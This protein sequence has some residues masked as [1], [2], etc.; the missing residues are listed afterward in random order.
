MNNVTYD[1]KIF[2]STSNTDNGEI[3]S[4]TTF[5]YREVDNV[6]WATY[7]GG[8]IKFGTLTGIKHPDG[9]LD[10]TY[11]HVNTD[12]EI[13]TGRCHSTPTILPDGRIRLHEAWQWTT[14]H[15]TAGESVIEE[16][17]ERP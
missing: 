17:I 13:K 11:Q 4:A 9:A 15:R 16:V 2:R 3:S 1:E 5:H 10:F 6:V 7:V 12:D 8:D 14:G